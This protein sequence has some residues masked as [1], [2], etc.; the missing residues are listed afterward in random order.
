M[1]HKEVWLDMNQLI[2]HA[3]YAYNDIVNRSI[4]KSHFEIVYGLHPRG[5]FELRELKDGIKWTG[6]DEKFS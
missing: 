2:R 1:S 6:Y 4:G 5:V 3:E